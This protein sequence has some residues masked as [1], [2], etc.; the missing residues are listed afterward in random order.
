MKGYFPLSVLGI[1]DAVAF[2]SYNPRCSRYQAQILMSQPALIYAA[3]RESF[4]RLVLENSR[5][6]L[7]PVDF[8][9]PWVGPSLRQRES[10]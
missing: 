7:V 9:A 2:Q 4:A 5:R 8:W 3:T 10:T 6:G 1:S